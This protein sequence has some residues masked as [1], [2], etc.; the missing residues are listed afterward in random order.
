M[1]DF[2]ERLLR[3]TDVKLKCVNKGVAHH[4]VRMRCHYLQ[5]VLSTMSFSGSQQNLCFVLHNGVGQAAVKDRPRKVCVGNKGK[6][7]VL[8]DAISTCVH[9][10]AEGSQIIGAN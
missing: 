8:N 1:S 10:E 3:T 2:G 5:F 6:A 9:K 4:M 7:R